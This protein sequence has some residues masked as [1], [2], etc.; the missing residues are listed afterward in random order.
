MSETPSLFDVHA[1]RPMSLTKLSVEIKRQVNAIGTVTVEGEVHRPSPVSRGRVFFSLRDRTAQIQVT[2]PASRA[3][4]VR[5]A[6]GERVA[7]T[8]LVAFYGDRGQVQLEATDVTPV[9][10]GA[11]AAAIIAARERLRIDG[12]LDRVRLPLPLLPACV[13]VVCG[14]DAAVRH[15]IE[16]VV[17]NRFPGYPVRFVETTVQGPGAAAA[18]ITALTMLDRHA[19]VEVIVLARGGGDPVSL[20]AFSDE[21]LC[22][23]I[24]A[25]RT[26]VVSAIGHEED[27][28]LSDEV[29]DHRAGTPSI[30]AS[31]VIP[32]R[33]ALHERL[34]AARRLAGAGALRGLER[35]HHRVERITWDGALDRRLERAHDRVA[36]VDWKRSFDRG[37]ERAMVRLDRVGWN[38]AMPRRVLDA[39]LRLDALH[40]EVEA[41]SPARVLERGYAVVRDADGRVLRRAD[42]VARGDVVRVTV[43]HGTFDADVR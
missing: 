24:C 15:D 23:A 17:A 32:N 10:E 20:L 11:V 7:V 14:T 30:A 3:R 41:L 42:A 33:L 31:M 22:R 21:E 38:E 8:G 5:I 29:A 2:V 28:P 9:G 39:E 27:R 1:A 12:L 25:S 16:S 37:V 43:A 4:F 6:T 35:A 19:D 26:A 40:R 36:R 18:I 34:D 13:G